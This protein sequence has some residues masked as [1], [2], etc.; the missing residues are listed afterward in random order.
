MESVGFMSG[1]ARRQLA[2]AG[3]VALV[4]YACAS[5]GRQR[6]GT[7]HRESVQWTFEGARAT[8]RKHARTEEGRRWEQANLSWFAPLSGPILTE[9]RRTAAEGYEKGFVLLLQIGHDGAI[10]TAL[11][12]PSTSY[13]E[14]VRTRISSLIFPRPA[15]PGY[16]L[17]IEAPESTMKLLY[18]T[19]S[20]D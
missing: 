17:E 12:E 10:D 6:S 8:A 14:C 7:D 4:T 15:W 5:T 16:W 9:C 1:S 2:I 11:I 20:S 13:A 19:D 3:L 18:G